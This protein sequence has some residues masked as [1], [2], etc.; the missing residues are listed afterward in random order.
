TRNM[1]AEVPVEYDAL[2]ERLSEE[3]LDRLQDEPAPNTRVQLF[4][5]PA[6]MARL[7]RPIYDFL[8]QIFEPTRYHANATLRGFYFTSGTQHG[9]PI[10]RLIGALEKSFG[11]EQVGAQAFSG[12]GK[13]FFIADL[14]LKVIIGEAAW[15]SSDRRAVRRGRILKT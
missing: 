3:T 7:K 12:R 10:D 4:G 6:Q 1:V 11:A 5:F 8:N 2:L 14:I 9:T 13:S 15:V